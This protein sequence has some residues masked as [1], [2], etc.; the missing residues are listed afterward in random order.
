MA[1]GCIF[2]GHIK[3]FIATSTLS[4][5]LALLFLVMLSVRTS[6]VLNLGEPIFENPYRMDHKVCNLLALTFICVEIL[7]ISVFALSL[8]VESCHRSS[9]ESLSISIVAHAQPTF[10]K[11]TAFM[12]WN[13]SYMDIFWRLRFPTLDLST[14]TRDRLKVFQ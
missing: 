8:L 7:C 5:S 2:D 14:L 12:V 6:R 11:M 4:S 9:L 1:F 13:K 3:C 10:Y